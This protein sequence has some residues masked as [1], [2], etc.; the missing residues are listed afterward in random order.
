MALKLP[1]LKALLYVLPFCTANR[2]TRW[3]YAYRETDKE[4]SVFF[5]QPSK[6]QKKRRKTKR[7][8]LLKSGNG[9]NSMRNFVLIA[10][11]YAFGLINLSG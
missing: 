11:M 8:S 3:K 6:Q 7:K 10:F 9:C 4:P 5:A 1:Q 2:V